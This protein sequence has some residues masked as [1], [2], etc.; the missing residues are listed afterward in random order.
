MSV[1]FNDFNIDINYALTDR[2][3]LA[4]TRHLSKQD[5]HHVLNEGCVT[6]KPETVAELVKLGADPLW[7]DQNGV[8]CI[9]K[10]LTHDNGNRVK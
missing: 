7:Q 6:F 1:L 3:I 10:V 5:F 9:D 4:M 8:S 2:I